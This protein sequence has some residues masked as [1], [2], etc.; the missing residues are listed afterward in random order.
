[1]LDRYTGLYGQTFPEV[2]ADYALEEK[3]VKQGALL[4][5]ENQRGVL[6]QGLGSSA[7]AANAAVPTA[8]PETLR[9]GLFKNRKLVDWAVFPVTPGVV[10]EETDTLTRAQWAALS[11]LP[12]NDNQCLTFYF[13]AQEVPL[14]AGDVLQEAVV[15]RDVYG[16]SLIHI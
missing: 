4:L 2:W 11:R 13:P 1:M 7:P 12:E 6:Y 15:I 16:L 9:V 3:P 5:E 14:E 10:E 8:E